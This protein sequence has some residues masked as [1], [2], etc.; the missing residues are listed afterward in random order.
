V[1]DP[2]VGQE[3]DVREKVTEASLVR[4]EG[5]VAP[6]GDGW[7]LVNVSET[8]GSDSDEYGHVASFEGDP[9]FPD[10]G[11]NVHVLRPGKPNCKYHR[12]TQQED[13]LVLSGECVAIVE[14]KELPMRRGDFLHTPAGTN[15]VLVGAGDGP[16]A[17]LMVGS[18]KEPDEVV[19][20]VSEVAGRY[21]GSVERETPDP[22]EAYVGRKRWPAPLGEVPW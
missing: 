17:V 1:L 5:G 6:Q 15:H 21:G 10:V 12:E 16:C 19:Y 20:P 13:F 9:E 11:I 8:V 2:V 3:E 22:K 4:G 14:D 7:F 18:R